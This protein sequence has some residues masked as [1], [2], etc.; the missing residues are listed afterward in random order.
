M[1]SE[2]VV[3]ISYKSDGSTHNYFFLSTQE[4]SM[5]PFNSD[6]RI[7]FVITM[8]WSVMFCIVKKNARKLVGKHDQSSF[9]FGLQVIRSE[10]K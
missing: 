10:K 3:L 9:V 7:I 4:G 5:A 6:V 8:R 1:T 2:Q